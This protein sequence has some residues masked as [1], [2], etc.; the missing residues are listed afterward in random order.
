MCL[1]VC[2]QYPTVVRKAPPVLQE[3]AVRAI[4][5]P[6]IVTGSLFPSG[7]VNAAWV[8]DISLSLLQLRIVVLAC[9]TIGRRA[10]HYPDLL[11]CNIEYSV[12]ER[13]INDV[14]H[15]SVHAIL[16]HP[17][18]KNSD[19]P[20]SSTALQGA[21][22]VKVQ[23]FVSRCIFLVLCLSASYGDTQMHGRAFQSLFVPMQRLLTLIVYSTIVA[24][25]R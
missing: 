12:V 16:G 13:H 5:H 6:A 7:D 4:H 24:D 10:A 18:S 8:N 1:N 15:W 14:R 25:F 9:P 21:P 3:H 2:L 23:C 17:S 20:Y 22:L 19:N 11:S